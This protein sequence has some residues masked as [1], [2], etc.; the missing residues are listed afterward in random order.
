MK[1]YCFCVLGLMI[2]KKDSVFGLIFLLFF[3]EE[4]K[5]VIEKDGNVI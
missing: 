3:G 2:L 5:I 4:S 1:A